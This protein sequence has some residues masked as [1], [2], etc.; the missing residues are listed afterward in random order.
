[1]A[2]RYTPNSLVRLT[3]EFRNVAGALADPTAVTITITDPSG[4]VTTPAAVND[5]TG[6]Y[7]VDVTAN[8]IG[9]WAYTWAGTGAVVA[10]DTDKFLVA[11][12]SLPYATAAQFRA[13]P[14]G[15]A[16]KAPAD[17]DQVLLQ[18]SAVIDEL[19][20]HGPG[21]F[22]AEGASARLFDGTGK[23]ELN[24]PSATAVTAVSVEGSAVP[25]GSWWEVRSRPDRPA[26]AILLANVYRFTGGYQNVSVTATWGYS[27]F[28]PL[29]IEHAC[30]LQAAEF[31]KE[32][33]SQTIAQPGRTGPAEN[34]G[35]TRVAQHIDRLIMPFKRVNPW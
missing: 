29:G 30:I 17:I 9:V 27:P 18:A 11:A 31:I 10:N 2:R 16:L 25:T 12:A 22:F 35:R 19:C 26:M 21:A 33:G 14:H 5:S 7:H 34:A 8:V 6:V 4:A 24:I 13:Y 28:P 20:G 3:N 23:R 1:M 15:T 32:K